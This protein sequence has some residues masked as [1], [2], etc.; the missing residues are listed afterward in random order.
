MDNNKIIHHYDV[1]ASHNDDKS[2]THIPNYGIYD[3]DDLVL[4]E[5]TNKPLVTINANKKAVM[6]IIGTNGEILRFE[7]NGDIFIHGE[8][9][10]NNKQI[11]NGFVE[12]LKTGQFSVK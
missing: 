6:T 11:I 9:A 12:F 10:D 8:L 3:Y 5:S 1:K 4:R 7:E 2:I